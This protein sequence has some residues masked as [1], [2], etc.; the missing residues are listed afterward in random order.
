VLVVNLYIPLS[1]GGEKSPERK[2]MLHMPEIGPRSYITPHFSPDLIGN[3]IF[4]VAYRS[5]NMLYGYVIGKPPGGLTTIDLDNYL[6]RRIAFQ[7]YPTFTGFKFY[8][9]LEA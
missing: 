3:N 7:V 4:Y 2:T 6:Q 8:E 1:S 9:D 5:G